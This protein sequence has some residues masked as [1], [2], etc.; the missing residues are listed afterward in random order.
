[1]LVLA[2]PRQ[3]DVDPDA[4]T[5]PA[6]DPATSATSLRDQESGSTRAQ[7]SS[8]AR[9]LADS[10]D[11]VTSQDVERQG[12][13]GS[14]LDIKPQERARASHRP[15]R[16][17]GGARVLVFRK[18]FQATE[19]EA[20]RFLRDTLKFATTH[21]TP[22]DEGRARSLF[23]SGR[24]RDLELYLFERLDRDR[25]GLVTWSEAQHCRLFDLSPAEWQQREDGG[26][27]ALYL[28]ADLDADGSLQA[29]VWRLQE[30]Q[31]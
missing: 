14:S 17:E 28:E 22:A 26:P 20:Q 9:Y 18:A 7:D 8:S 29:S 1:M 12:S 13:H 30:T 23:L 16:E 3:Q 24:F 25:D 2:S 11:E 27:A 31:L 6:T 19:Q 4:S 21:D 15:G 5:N 10:A